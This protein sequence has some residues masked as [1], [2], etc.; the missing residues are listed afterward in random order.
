[1]G[2]HTVL[3]LDL[4]PTMIDQALDRAA[5]LIA[6]SDAILIGAGAGMGVDSGLPDFRGNQGFWRAY[7]PYER[8]GL[9][10]VSL[11]NP[12]WFIADPGLA[13]GFYGHRMELYR[14]TIPHPGFAL[15]RSWATG[16]QRG[17]FVFTSNVDGHFQRSGFGPEQIVEVHGSFE[18][19]Q[20]TGECGVGIFPGGPMEVRID[21]KTMRA[22]RGLPSC[23]RCG[24]LARP[25]ILMFGDFEWN[26]TR[27]DAQM[28]RMRSWLG[29]LDQAKLVIIECGAG[30]AL[31]TV[32]MTCEHIAREYGG[33]LIRINTREPE[34]PLGHL[35][36]PLRAL[37]ALESLA[38]RLG[39]AA[40]EERA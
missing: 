2:P 13:W 7:P 18:G 31:P 12:R 11:A 34:A 36:L 39:A 6:L 19:M 1:M 35:S 10:F 8:L 27:T 24:A 3:S 37:V 9:D 4:C 26:S 38:A 30:L 33:T 25:N 20:C 15:L 14:R 23:P 5:R 16:K 21:S 22:V 40:A 17:G 29:S 28:R 32:R